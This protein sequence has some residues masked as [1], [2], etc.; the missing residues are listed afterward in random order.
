MIEANACDKEKSGGAPL[1]PAISE[2]LKNVWI[3]VSTLSRILMA[4]CLF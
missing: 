1:E 2:I 4:M 3:H